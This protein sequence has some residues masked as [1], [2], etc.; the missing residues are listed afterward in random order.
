MDYEGP[1]KVEEGATLVFPFMVYDPFLQTTDIN[2]NIYTEEGELYSSSPLQVD[3]SP[4]EWVTQDYPS[5][6]TRFEITCKDTAASQVIEVMPTTF[7]KE[8]IT[9]GCVLNFNARGRSNNESNPASWEYEGITAEFNGFG[10]ANVDGWMDIK[11]K[12]TGIIKD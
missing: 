10:W 8:I 4:K 12:E 7:D 5:G 9:D 3:Q 6:K 2:L 11:D 1:E